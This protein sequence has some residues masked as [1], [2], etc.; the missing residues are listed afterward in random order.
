MYRR[1]VGWVLVVAVALGVTGLSV[2]PVRATVSGQTC[3]GRTPTIETTGGGTVLG[4]GGRDVIIALGGATVY[5]GA[6]GDFI[7]VD[8]FATV[9][10]G[11]GDDVIRGDGPD[12]FHLRPCASYAYGGSGDDVIFCALY[13][14]GGSGSDSLEVGWELRG[15]SGG[16]TLYFGETVCDGGS[17]KDAVTGLCP[18]TKNVP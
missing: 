11:A 16:D 1:S 8:G 5:G 10:G 17:G 4:T 6:G 13:Q 14:F 7:C 15:E 12:G 3:G 9:Y 2:S 18:V